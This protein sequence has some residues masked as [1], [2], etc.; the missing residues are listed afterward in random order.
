VQLS[1]ALDA[2]VRDNAER[3]RFWVRRLHVPDQ[4]AGDLVQD[5]LVVLCERLDEVT[6]SAWLPWLRAAVEYKEKQRRRDYARW[7]QQEPY[8]T[9][10]VL[11]T[12]PPANACPEAVLE[13]RDL[14]AKVGRFIDE[15]APERG[16]VARRYL[17]QN[18]PMGYIAATLGVALD[19]V[20]TRWRLAKEDI[21]AAFVRERAKER[22][23]AGAIVVFL[24]LL[25][26]RARRLVRGEAMATAR[27]PSSALRRTPGTRRIGTDPSAPWLALAIVGG[28]LGLVTCALDHASDRSLKVSVAQQE[29][30]SAFATSS[31]AGQ[32][33]PSRSGPEPEASP[34]NQRA[35]QPASPAVQKVT[36]EPSLVAS[37]TAHAASD[38]TP[39]MRARALLARA[40]T[41]LKQGALSD[42][43]EVLRRYETEHPDNPFPDHHVGLRVDLAVA[44][45]PR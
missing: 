41:Y 42:A 34:E 26:E 5:A 20:K 21:E 32:V 19:T 36:E 9:N 44:S 23:H 29:T 38:P 12:V 37:P 45:H 15:L 2:F 8:L 39:R 28:L 30:E 25:W 35:V 14:V 16:E 31:L 6:P 18:E 17:L 24:A 11:L 13:D 4:D 40:Q 1:A 33:A 3:A 7:K 27:A 10:L 22:L 43:A